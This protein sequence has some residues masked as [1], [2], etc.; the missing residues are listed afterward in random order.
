MQPPL[1]QWTRD[2]SLMLAKMHR[3]E[4]NLTLFQTCSW[5]HDREMVIKPLFKQQTACLL[6][7]T[8]L[9][10]LI[11]P[12]INLGTYK[13]SVWWRFRLRGQWAIFWKILSHCLHILHTCADICLNGVLT[14]E[15][16]H[17][18]LPWR[19]CRVVKLSYA[20]ITGLSLT[21][22]LLATQMRHDW[23]S[24]CLEKHRVK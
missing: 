15:S 11:T 22:T 9:H 1:Y 20:G 4:L 17:P 16:S 24:E 12:R 23:K 2:Q 6:N 10:C 18:V 19:S 8:T 21:G 5:P 13:L 3:A 7:D 14:I